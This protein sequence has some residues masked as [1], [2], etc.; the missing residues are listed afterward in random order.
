MKS[1][2]LTSKAYDGRYLQLECV[3]EPDPAANCS[4]VTWTLTV[5]GGADPYYSTGPTTVRIG[6]EQQWYCKRKSYTTK[7]FPAAK[8]SVTGSLTVPHEADGSCTLAVSLET[9]I[10]TQTTSV[11]E[12]S[13]QLDP[14]R[15]ASVISATDATVGSSATVVISRQSSA[16]RHSVY[17]RFG[18]LQG[19][20]DE[21]GAPCDS[22]V[23]H[24]STTLSFPLPEVFY[25]QLKDRPQLNCLLT[26]YTWLEGEVVGKDSCNFFVSTDPALCGP[27]VLAVTAPAD[28]L[29]LSLTDGLLIP[30]ISTVRCTVTATARKYARIEKILVEG[31]ETEGEALLAQWRKPTVRVVVID[32]RG[33][34]A[35][36][37][38]VCSYVNY[39]EPTNLATVERPEPTADSAVLTLQGAGFQGSFGLRDN[40]LTATVEFDG[41]TLTVPLTLEEGSYRQTVTLEG[42]SYLRSYPVTVTVSDL[43]MSVSL[44][45]TVR[46]GLPVFQ[47]SETDFKFHVP[48]DLPALTVNGIPLADYIRTIINS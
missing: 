46:K 38:A 28:E 30:G 41:R 23:I 14:I 48:V 27:Q 33:H 4:L 3:Q 21:T 31:A 18:G 5:A 16:F 22:E 29:T 10:Y 19:W 39:S 20:L 42:L 1:I 26:C 9:A 40:G 15:Q 13:W 35:G 25:S 11:V 44:P 17:Y 12:D 24:G 2:M 6:G 32:S 45:L 7:A 37:E 8:G 36:T 47:W 34:R 43:A